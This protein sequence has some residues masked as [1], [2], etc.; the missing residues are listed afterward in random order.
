MSKKLL[1][2]L[3]TKVENVSAE[4]EAWAK[5]KAAELEAEDAK[6][7]VQEQPAADAPVVAEEV[8]A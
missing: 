7:A 8:K 1:E 4:V 2:E 5:G 6:A 3:L